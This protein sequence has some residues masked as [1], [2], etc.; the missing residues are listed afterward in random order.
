MKGSES[1]TGVQFI[2]HIKIFCTKNEHIYSIYTPEAFRQAGRL[3]VNEI[4]DRRATLRPR[5]NHV[6]LTKSNLATR[7]GRLA[8]SLALTHTRSALAE[9]NSVGLTRFPKHSNTTS[10][11]WH[12]TMRWFDISVRII[13]FL[14]PSINV[15]TNLWHFQKNRCFKIQ[16]GERN[17]I[18]P[19]T[20]KK[21]CIRISHY[22]Y[23]HSRY[24]VFAAHFV[25]VIVII[26]FAIIIIIIAIIITNVMHNHY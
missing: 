7:V 17:L 3:G 9:E 14:N 6:F 20:A 26:T 24:I 18:Y 15:Q 22:C 1:T 19:H 11:H 2:Q 25:F 21:S 12:V 16:H 5:P 10:R 4:G 13:G 8:E 23:H